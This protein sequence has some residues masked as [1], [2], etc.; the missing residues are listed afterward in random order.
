[1]LFAS[2]NDV[3]LYGGFVRTVVFIYMTWAAIITYV[4]E[5]DPIVVLL[6]MGVE[7]QVIGVGAVSLNRDCFGM[8]FVSSSLLPC[9]PLAF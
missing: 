7:S 1:M 3:S 9:Q 6:Y 8:P 2:D 4:H 5:V